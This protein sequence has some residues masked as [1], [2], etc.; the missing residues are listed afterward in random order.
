MTWQNNIFDHGDMLQA[1]PKQHGCTPLAYVWTPCIIC[2]W[3]K[4]HLIRVKCPKH[5]LLSQNLTKKSTWKDKITPGFFPF[6]FIVKV[7]KSFNNLKK[8]TKI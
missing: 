2:F 5:S 7:E 3:L 8:N 4:N 6:F 1:P